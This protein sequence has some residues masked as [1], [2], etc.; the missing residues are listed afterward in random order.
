LEERQKR[1]GRLFGCPLAIVIAALAGIAQA[2]SGVWTTGGPYGGPVNALAIDH[3]TPSTLYAGTIAGVFKSMDAAGTWSAASAGLTDRNIQALA[4]DPSTSSTL[5]AGSFG[6]R[7]FKSTDSGGSWATAS[8]GLPATESAEVLALT[9]DYSNP[10]TLYAATGR[11]L[12][13]ST[14]GGGRWVD[15]NLT[16]GPATGFAIDPVTPSTLYATGDGFFKSTDAGG[17]WTRLTLFSGN[18]LVIDPTNPSTMYEGTYSYGVFRST[19]AG[20]TWTAMTTGLPTHPGE[21]NFYPVML[22]M[23]PTTPSRLYAGTNGGGILKS[24]DFYGQRWV[25]ASQGLTNLNVLA[26]AIDPSTPST[27]FVGTEVGIFKSVDSGLTWTAANNGLKLI[28]IGVRA[29]AIDPSTPSTLYVGTDGSGV[30]RS[31]DSGATWVTA[32]TGLTDLHVQALA[33]SLTNPPTIYAGTYRSGIFRSA[34]AGGTWTQTGLTSGGGALAISPLSPSTLYAA[35]GPGVVKS[36]DGGVTWR[37]CLEN[38]AIAG[39]ATGAS[40]PSTV[41]AWA[42][43]SGA[44]YFYRALFKSTD[45]GES[46]TDLSTKLPTS[47]FVGPVALDPASPSTLYAGGGAG[48]IKSTDGGES[49]TLA[50]NGL[51]DYALSLAIDPST[52]STLYVGTYSEGI[53]RSTDAGETWTAFNT[54]LPWTPGHMPPVSAL[55]VNPLTKTVHAGFIRGSVWQLTA[56]GV[57][58][59]SVT[60]S[61]VLSAAGLNGSFFTSELTLTNRGSAE[62]SMT[63]TYTSALGGSSGTASDI[64]PAG[65]QKILPDAIEYLRGLGIPVGD[66]GDRRGTLR[67]EFSGPAS[68]T[69]RTTTPVPEGRAGVSYT[70]LPASRLLSAPVYI[71]GLRQNV[72]DRSNVAV[73]NAGTALDGPITLRLTVFSGDPAQPQTRVLP[74]ITLPPGGFSQVSGIL[75]SNGLSLTNGYVRVEEVSGSAPFYAYGVINDQANSDGSFV[76]PVPVNPGLAPPVLTLPVIVESPLLSSELV[77]TNLS[78]DSLPR[79]VHFVY[80]ASALTGGQAAFDITLLAGEQQ[81]LPAI[82]QLLRDRGVIHDRPGGTFAGAVFVT[83]SGPYAGKLSVAARSST[84]GGG[85]RYGVYYA[86]VPAGSEAT[87]T[88]WLDDLQQ[89]SGNRTNLALV[90]VGSLDASTDTFR[91]D[92]FDGETGQKAGAAENVTVPAKG[93][94]QLNSILSRY[95]PSISNGYALVTRTVGNNPFI[96]YAVMNDGGAPGEGSGDG[97]FIE[98]DV[99]PGVRSD[100]VRT[101]LHVAPR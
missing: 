19:D 13:K 92:L 65:S 43:Y 3:R 14:D 72:Y 59:H 83:D 16:T 18:S 40:A 63:Y 85:G 52:P 53:F 82:V 22:A 67:I 55:A 76:Q 88:A 89:N 84:P 26:V 99:S 20:T 101:N 78:P 98:A 29:L 91:I 12:Y 50:N 48:M 45:S 6:G 71:C 80:V 87:T 58:P 27:L 36:T 94:L 93:F 81:I 56:L 90:N 49:W 15:T 34:D 51:T 57:E 95:A 44:Q 61:I 75:A 9:I 7:V 35:A 10:L 37:T 73:L 69:V 42:Y 21:S 86:A 66:S 46:W 38:L 41:Y 68:A 54:G 60:V 39:L 25:Q 5:Y 79:T 2:G 32:D 31:R 100:S 47:W 17:T 4:I 28:S 96:A 1:F 62:V 30:Y 24:T 70:G 33:V 74:D 64:L 11:G 97:A 8:N 23:D 77:L